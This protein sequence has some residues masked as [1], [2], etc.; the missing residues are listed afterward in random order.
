[1]LRLLILTLTLFS[2]LPTIAMRAKNIIQLP[3]CVK[4]RS[5][6]TM[7]KGDFAKLWSG[8]K[9]YPLSPEEF[10]STLATMKKDKDDFDKVW[11]SL[12]WDV[13]YLESVLDANGE[14]SWADGS[15][16][17]LYFWNPKGAVEF[18]RMP[19]LGVALLGIPLTVLAGGASISGELGN[20]LLK[21]LETPESWAIACKSIANMAEH[22][23]LWCVGATVATGAFA[24]SPETKL[25]KKYLKRFS[26]TNKVYQI[27]K[28][29]LAHVASLIEQN[30][31]KLPFSVTTSSTDGFKITKY[32]PREKE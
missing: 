14:D 9:G 22:A 8:K 20:V 1:M 23:T 18:M 27:N 29:N 3:K 12:Y 13:E 11:T 19:A 25:A 21:V 30:G 4:H 6:A 15:T 16:R 26:Y 31:G 28:A 2:T 5:Y 17:P 32:E 7:T 10:A 24:F